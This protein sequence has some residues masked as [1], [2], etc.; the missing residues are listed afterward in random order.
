[1]RFLEEN[2]TY[3]MQKNSNFDIFES[4]F[5]SKSGST[6]LRIKKNYII[7]REESGRHSTLVWMYGALHRNVGAKELT[8]LRK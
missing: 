6:P 2:Y 8:F 3:E 1:M 5:H 4:T 7:S